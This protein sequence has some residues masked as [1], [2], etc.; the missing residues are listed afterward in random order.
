MI[1][2]ETFRAPHLFSVRIVR[3]TATAATLR[4]KFTAARR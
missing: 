2:G 3:A 4:L 1:A